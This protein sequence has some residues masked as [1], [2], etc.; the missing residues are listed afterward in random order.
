MTVLVASSCVDLR[1]GSS[2]FAPTP[3][4]RQGLISVSSIRDAVC[5][6]DVQYMPGFGA[7]LLI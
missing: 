7:S 4:R 3:T 6:N 2:S 5:R 1:D